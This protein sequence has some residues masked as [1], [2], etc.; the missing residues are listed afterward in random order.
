MSTTRVLIVDDQESFRRHLR[1]LFT[2]AGLD[3]IGEA[4]DIPEARELTRSLQPDLAIIDINLPGE[5]G[6]SGAPQLIALAPNMRVILISAQQD[7]AQVL[8]K[9]AQ[10]VGVAAF[11]LK[12][13]LELELVKKWMNLPFAG[14]NQGENYRVQGTENE[15]D[16]L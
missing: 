10:E 11:V 2:Q 14:K 1:Q 5:S 15:G 4:G 6:I 13:D 3:V 9:S 16:V 12:D 7:Y 8:Q